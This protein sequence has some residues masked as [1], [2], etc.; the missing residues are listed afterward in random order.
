MGSLIYEYLKNSHNIIGID[1]INHPDVKMIKNINNIDLDLIIDFSDASCYEYL[2]EGIKKHIPVFSGTTTYSIEQISYLSNLAKELNSV[3]VWKPNYA[4]GVKVVSE[5]IN[6]C[7]D[8]YNIVDLV[9]THDIN[10]KDSPSGTAKLLV[11]VLDSKINIQSLRLIK[12]N[13]VHEI[14]F[15]DS[16]ERITIKYESLSKMSFVLGLMEEIKRFGVDVDVG[17]IV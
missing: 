1:I 3:F 17:N 14:I 4:K 6:V 13:A 7:K 9:E 5:L 11:N 12:S 8:N 2:L 16:N 10:K 15:Y